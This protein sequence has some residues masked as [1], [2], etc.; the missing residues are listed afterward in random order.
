MNFLT[1]KELAALENFNFYP[2]GNVPNSLMGWLK[3]SLGSLLLLKRRV[4][5]TFSS[6]I[7]FSYDGPFSDKN[8][9]LLDPNIKAS[10]YKTRLVLHHYATSAAHKN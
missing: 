1:E 4:H 9:N 7:V 8:N 6:N 10:S 3:S 2:A 5:S